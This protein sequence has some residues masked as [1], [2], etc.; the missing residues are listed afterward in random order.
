VG[1]FLESGRMCRL[2]S[3]MPWLGLTSMGMYYWSE[4]P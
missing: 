2:C 4:S 3:Y 1:F